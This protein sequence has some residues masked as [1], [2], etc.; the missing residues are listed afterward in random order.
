MTGGADSWWKTELE[1][2][3]T[4]LWLASPKP[5]LIPP[6]HA[7]IY[8]P[9]GVLLC[10]ALPMVLL[11][12]GAGDNLWFLAAGLG[13]FLFGL[14][15]DQFLRK[16]R[17]HAVIDRRVLEFNRMSPAKSLPVDSRLVFK[18]GLHS[19][20]FEDRLTFSFQNLTDPDAAIRALQ[21]AREAAG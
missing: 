9:L 19:V 15:T 18:R 12:S 20:N 16:R 7:R 5:S 21:Q 13:L 17:V 10:L 3:E 11:R 14:L 6:Q 4:L 8:G 2:G 1:A